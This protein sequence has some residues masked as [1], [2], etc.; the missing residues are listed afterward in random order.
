MNSDNSYYSKYLKYKNKYLDL[1]QKISGGANTDGS[2]G[3]QNATSDL[4]QQSTESLINK[5][6]DV[7]T[8]DKMREVPGTKILTSEDKEQIIVEVEALNQELLK[9]KAVGEQYVAEYRQINQ[10]IDDATT[11][12]G[13]GEEVQVTDIIDKLVLLESKVQKGVDDPHLTL[14]YLIIEILDS[15]QDGKLEKAEIL[16][17]KKIIEDNKKHIDELKTANK[18]L[19]R[20]L[21]SSTIASNLGSTQR[22]KK[23]N[24]LQS[25]N[26]ELES[27]NKKLKESR[28]KANDAVNRLLDFFKF[29]NMKVRQPVYI[30]R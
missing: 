3:T 25:Q 21:E 12:I 9:V 15:I 8:L 16:Q 22:L 2:L 26:K 4:I 27:E 1:K 11:A 10:L 6:S 24:N 13:S 7:M 19:E 5:I 23:I 28:R 29:K 18:E 17:L 14:Y 30:R 20:N